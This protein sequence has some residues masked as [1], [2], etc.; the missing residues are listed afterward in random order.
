MEYSKFLIIEKEGKRVIIK[1]QK[2]KG[3]IESK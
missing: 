2:Q 1:K 3:K